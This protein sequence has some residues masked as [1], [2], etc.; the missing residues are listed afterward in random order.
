MYNIYWGL[1][2]ISLLSFFNSA[3]GQGMGM[4]LPGTD[5][6][7]CCSYTKSDLSDEEVQACVTD[8]Q[9]EQSVE[10]VCRETFENGPVPHLYSHSEVD[11][12]PAKAEEFSQASQCR[13]G[14]RAIG[15]CIVVEGVDRKPFPNGEIYPNPISRSKAGHEKLKIK[16][17][18][19]LSLALSHPDCKDQSRFCIVLSPRSVGDV[20]KNLKMSL[21]L[22]SQQSYLFFETPVGGDGYFDHQ[23]ELRQAGVDYVDLSLAD[24]DFEVDAEYFTLKLDRKIFTVPGVYILY[25]KG[26]YWQSKAIKVLVEP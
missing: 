9:I 1:I 24:P 3:Y 17:H 11:I 10:R 4:I 16:F 23:Q 12:E 13:A 7:L 8:N 22:V 20:Y 26:Y 6:N 14:I 5:H 25:F 19:D 2:L 21:F 15:S 18:R